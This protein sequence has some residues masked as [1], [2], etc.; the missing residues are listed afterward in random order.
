[1]IEVEHLSRYYGEH[2]AVDD[3]SFNIGANTVV[4]FLGLN[5][6]GKTTTLKVI[7]GRLPASAGTVRIEGVDMSEAPDTF[8]TRLSFL[9]ETPPLYPEMTVREF[10]SFVGKLRGMK[11]A[12][13]EA[14]IPE[15]LEKC[16]LTPRADWVIDTLSH[17]YRKR[18]G[19][20]S[21]IIHQPR[22]VILDEPISGLDPEQIIE[23]RRVVRDLGKE[24]T[25]LVSSHIL[26]E[27]RQTCDRVLVLKKGRLVYEGTEANLHSQAGACA[28]RLATR[29]PAARL[30]AAAQGLSLV[31][32][33][34][35]ESEHQGITTATLALRED[36][37]EDLIAALVGAGIGIRRL[38]DAVD[39]LERAFL[40]LTREGA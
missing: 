14:R 20:A 4:G 22:L 27:V 40:D 17:G 15:V 23:M 2:R 38:E 30:L 21:A 7:A 32:S 37:R 5:G 24:C 34:E 33:I 6:A 31:A 36:R 12:A 39:E 26:P 29:C 28:I 19:I 35:V 1:M 3:V 25:V 13:V 9:P 8:R 10:L 18:V 11:S 16:R